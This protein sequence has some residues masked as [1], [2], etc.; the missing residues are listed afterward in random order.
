MRP[1]DHFKFERP[2]PPPPRV[3]ANLELKGRALGRLQTYL[4]R[5]CRAVPD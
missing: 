3:L 4:V 2:R 1:L 5:R